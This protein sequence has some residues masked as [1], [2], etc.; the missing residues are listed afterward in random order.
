MHEESFVHIRENYRA[1]A[2]WFQ[3]TDCNRILHWQVRTSTEQPMSKY[4]LAH[5]SVE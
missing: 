2:T 3:H 4:V 5:C 1:I